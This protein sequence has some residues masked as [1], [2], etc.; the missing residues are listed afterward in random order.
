MSE[1][2]KGFQISIRYLL[3]P[4]L[5][6]IIVFVVYLMNYLG[7]F[8]PV[9]IQEKKAGPFHLVY[10]THVGPYHKIV[11]VIEEVEKWAKEQGLS[12]KLSFGEYL[13]SPSQTEEARLRS[14]G[15]CLLENPPVQIPEGFQAKTI[16]EKNYVTAKFEGSPGIG[17]MKV[18]P[19]V[20]QY[21]SEQRLRLEEAVLEVYEIHSQESMTTTYYFPIRR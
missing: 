19:K 16:E 9:V 11:P 8:R 2:K 3:L 21:A 1:E 6:A 20:Y 13:D 17:P 15:G 12:C 7:A 4:L 10:K 18:Y 14:N 5:I